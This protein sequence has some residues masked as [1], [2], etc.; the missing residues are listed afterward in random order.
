MEWSSS[1][2]SSELS[3]TTVADMNLKTLIL[4]FWQEQAKISNTV[5]L[6]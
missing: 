2:K 5:D 1:M 4:E 6:S 3:L